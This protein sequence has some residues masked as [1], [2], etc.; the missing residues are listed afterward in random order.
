MAILATAVGFTKQPGYVLNFLPGLILLAALVITS[1]RSRPVMIAVLSVV[2]AVNLFTFLAWPTSWDGLFFGL[3]RTARE[4]RDRDETI[5][6]T[7]H[8]IRAH[9]SPRDVVICHATEYLPFGIRQLQLYLPEFDEY[10]MYLDKVMVTP[11]GRPMM[12]IRSGQLSYVDGLDA[13]GKR[14]IILIVPPGRWLREFSP[15]CEVTQAAL[16]PDSDGIVYTLDPKW[17][18]P[19]GASRTGG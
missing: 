16:V 5:S 14:T 13:N 2:C 3:G 4:I 11:R 15:Y 12:S 8:I 7:V 6:K 19:S 9:F 1:L 18:F 10:L 17:V